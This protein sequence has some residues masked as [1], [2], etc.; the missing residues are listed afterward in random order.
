MTQQE[1]AQLDKMKKAKNFRKLNKKIQTGKIVCA[2]SS[3][4]EMFPIEKFLVETGRQTIIYN[5][6][7]GGYMV[8]E[9][10]DNLDVC[11]LD[12]KPSR[13]FINI[14]TNDLSWSSIT[15]EQLIKS[16]ESVLEDVYKALPDIEVYVMAYF[17]INYEAASEEMK[18]CLLIRT[19][20]RIN[21]ANIAL[22]KMAEKF[23]ARYID[24]N[25]RLK[26]DLGRLKAEYTIEGMH[27]K[28]EGYKAIFDD[29]MKYADE[30]AWDRD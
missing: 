7:I 24:V 21:E 6:G 29:F 23:G 16:Y 25:D 17:P 9:L 30:P 8:K 11:V 22:S 19:N 26:D 20:E 27:I 3:L 28:E 5:R 12:L 1:Q 13:L 10:H 14:G 4:M 2:G 18:P 15:I